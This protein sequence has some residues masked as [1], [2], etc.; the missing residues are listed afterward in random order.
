M[1][2]PKVIETPEAVDSIIQY[3]LTMNPPT[4][5]KKTLDDEDNLFVTTM[6]YC[7]TK[8]KSAVNSQDKIRQFYAK[9]G[10]K[11]LN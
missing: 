1:A 8:E 2:H 3:K 7:Q 11:C 9:E 6:L 5:T 4:Y 10:I